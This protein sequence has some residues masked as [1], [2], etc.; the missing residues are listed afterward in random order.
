MNSKSDAVSRPSLPK[1]VKFAVKQPNINTSLLL[2]PKAMEELY[3]QLDL[4]MR[5]RKEM[6]D[7]AVIYVLSLGYEPTDLCIIY[8]NEHG[9]ETDRLFVRDELCFEVRVTRTE[10]IKGKSTITTEPKLYAW[11]T[12]K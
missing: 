9:I 6:L 12:S 1:K 11:P 10:F 8:D 5:P 2:D 7:V 3:V 4:A